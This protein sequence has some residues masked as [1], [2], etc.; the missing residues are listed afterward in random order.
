MKFRERWQSKRC[1]R[2]SNG[3]GKFGERPT[4][5]ARGCSPAR[6][7]RRGVD[8]SH[9]VAIPE[10]APAWRGR[11]FAFAAA[12]LLLFTTAGAT[13]ALYVHAALRGALR[14]RSDGARSPEAPSVIAAAPERPAARRSRRRSWFRARSSSVPIG[15]CLPRSP[16]RR[17]SISCNELNPTT[18]A[19]TS[20]TRSCSSRS[21][22]AGSPTDGWRRSAKR[23]GCDRSPG[24]AA[25]TKRAGAL[26][27][28]ARRF[29][30][31]VLLPRLREQ[32]RAA[33]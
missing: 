13:A 14:D 28:F 31:S 17:S 3:D 7:G 21:T 2:S 29:P 27:A 15:C 11:R 32:A 23:C 22:L 19:R 5:C 25:V 8:P 4:W 33:E 26:A 24:R 6:G 16:T 20:P 12:A 10:T 1:R 9:R 18:P 30:R